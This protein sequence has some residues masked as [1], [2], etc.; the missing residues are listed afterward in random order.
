MAVLSKFMRLSKRE[1]EEHRVAIAR[2]SV[3]PAIGFYTV[4]VES[5]SDD[6][7]RRDK[8]EKDEYRSVEVP[9]D[10]KGDREQTFTEKVRLFRDGTPEEYCFL[11]ERVEE[12]AQKLGIEGDNLTEAEKAEKAAN[13]LIN[14]YSMAFEGRARMRFL[15]ALH[16]NSLKSSREKLELALNDVAFGIFNHPRQA[17]EIQRKYLRKSGLK[18]YRVRPAVFGRRLEL[19]NRYLEYFPREMRADGT[20]KKNEPISDE[21]LIDILMDA[22]T[23]ALQQT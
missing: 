15:H 2:L 7:D 22:R 21:E 3:Q 8:S 10:P 19:L 13:Q 4:S 20:L 14:L 5:K 11:R 6:A 17:Y 9:I 12:L 18:M 1:W 16:E 23:T